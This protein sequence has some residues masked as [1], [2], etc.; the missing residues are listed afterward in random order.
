MD[1]KTKELQ[2]A[3]EKVINHK[4][5]S[6]IV[7][8]INNNDGLEL[9]VGKGKVAA[10]A[11]LIADLFEKQ[12]A[13]EQMVKDAKSLKSGKLPDDLVKALFNALGGNSNE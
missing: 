13:L 10:I 5:D 12:P 6:F 4:L 11:V 9:S 8:G 1:N 7:L 2:K 3:V